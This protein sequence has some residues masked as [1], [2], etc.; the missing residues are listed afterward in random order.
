MWD[1]INCH[2]LGRHENSISCVHG[3]IHL[4]CLRCGHRS[5]GWQVEERKFAFES[6]PRPARRPFLLLEARRS[7]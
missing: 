3:S 2:L 7:R 1:W 5:E 6:A 4:K